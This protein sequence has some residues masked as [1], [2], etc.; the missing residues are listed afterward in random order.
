MKKL[1]FG[2]ISI[3]TIS[4]AAQTEPGMEIVSLGVN[5]TLVRLGKVS[6]IVLLPIQ[7]TA[8]MAQVRVLT[9]GKLTESINA[10]LASSRVDYYVPVYVNNA[11]GQSVVLDV[12]THFD[13]TSLREKD[14]AAWINEISLGETF[15]TTNRE[16]FRPVY[17]HTPAYGWMNDPNGMFYKDGVWHLCYQWNPYGSKWQNLSWGHSTSRDLAHW[18]SEKPALLPD[19]LGMVFSGSCVVDTAGTAGFGKDAVVAIYTSADASQTQSLAY[20]TDGGYTFTRFEGNPIITYPHESR[21]PNMFWHDPTQQWVLTLAAAQDH[22]MLIYTSK[23]LKDWTLASKF[24]KGYGFQNAEWECPDLMEVPVEG[25]DQKKWVMVCNIN[26][27][28]PAGGSGTQYFVGDFDGQTFTADTAPEVTKF[29]DYGKDH[30]A[31]VTFSG[32]PGEK[33]VLLAWM[34][35]WQYANE[36]PTKQYRSANTLPREMSLFKAPDG[37]MYL[38]VRPAAELNS[39]RARSNITKGFTAGKSAKGIALPANGLCEIE[40]SGVAR[41]GASLVLTL[42]NGAGEQ[43]VMTLNPWEQSFSMDRT[44]SGVVDFSENFPAVTV[45]PT[46]REGGE[47]ALRIFV[48]RSSVEAFDAEGR[49]AMTNRVFPNDPYTSLQVKAEGGKVKVNRV[50]VHAIND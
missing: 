24:G 30:Y 5:N 31:A 22:E 11:Q 43:V 15:D 4:G 14:D 25:T 40:V 41:E 47:F 28:N 36:L 17:H 1:I 6:P 16:K 50:T 12:R 13:R 3:C 18:E 29:M 2:V 34:S 21:D 37:E 45:A 32:A 26:P 20:S 35:N 39:L 27:G 42:A 46:H 9:D 48:D 7:E 23:N 33:P 8:P 44:R 38:A 49:F 19:D 10:P